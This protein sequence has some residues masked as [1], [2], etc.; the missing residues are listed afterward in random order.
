MVLITHDREGFGSVGS[1]TWNQ[2]HN[3]RTVIRQ[4]TDL[5]RLLMN[6]RLIGRQFAVVDPMCEKTSAKSAIRDCR[7]HGLSSEM[8]RALETCS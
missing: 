6:G 1:T 2:A 4:R 3:C 7:K 5:S 8:P